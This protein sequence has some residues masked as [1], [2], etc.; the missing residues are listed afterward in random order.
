M[1]LRRI[2]KLL[3]AF[4][5]SQGVTTLSQLI[6]P[7][8]FL[9]RYPHG[10]EMYG[11]WIA[12]TAA[13][14]YLGT[15][16]SGIQTY[17]NTQ[18]TLHYNRGEIKETKVVQSSALRIMMMMVLVAAGAGVAT[19]FMPIAS[20]M[21][22]RHISSRAA[23]LTL[24]LMVLQLV[25]GWIFAFLSN[26]YLV[27][28]KL[29]RGTV[30]QNLQ[31][32]T[33][34]LS[35]A[36]FLW[37][38]A[39][40]P[41]L[42]LTQLASMVLFTLIVLVEM[43]LRAPILLPSLRYG[44][45]Q[46]LWGVLKPSAYYM[47]YTF[48]GFLCWQGPVLLIQK[49]L[50]PAVVAM[51]AVT[52]AIFNMARQCVMIFTQSVSQQNIE[53]IARRNWKQLLRMYDLSERVVFFLN[54]A[55]TIGAVLACPFL[56]AVWLHKGGL[57]DPFIC[58]MIA[59]SSSSMALSHHKYSFQYLSNRHEGVA[60]VSMAAYGGMTVVTA[61]TIRT[62]GIHAYLA[63]WLAAELL[64]CV[65]VIRQN[66]LLF[67]KEFRP[68]LAPLPRFALLM[69][70]AFGLALWPALHDGSW[71]LYR[72]AMMAAA[73]TVALMIVSYFAFGL[74]DVLAVFQNRFRRRF[75]VR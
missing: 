74:R 16:N 33:A 23:A 37:A 30:W 25:V 62:W 5:M 72:V 6:V 49:F 22:L 10:V 18:M 64:I 28:G 40:F 7:P 44:N 20:W 32:L 43:R 60:K 4:F 12:L 65:Y 53:L 56:L 2:L 31:R 41:I 75:A 71:P 17:G 14:S 70:V 66:Q 11:E 8:I 19:L 52:R 61:L 35:L 63:A 9:H 50:G 42:A 27:L 45:L 55:W 54:P 57:Y 73:A 36:V 39:P 59:A 34:M 69:A 29:H 13:V 67:P 1:S 24:L 58:I 46:D 3:G 51:F 26:S 21:G 47:L 15:L 38:H 68:S 48:S